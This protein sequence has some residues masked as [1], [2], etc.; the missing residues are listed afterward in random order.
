M[1]FFH[2][3]GVY[4]LVTRE[5]AVRSGKGKIIKGRWLDVNKG[6]SVNPDYRSRLVGKEFNTGVDSTLY[7]AAPGSTE[8][9][10]QH[11]GQ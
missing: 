10:D 11:S 2:K 9:A 8:A 1:E 7:A 4:E 3:T 5:E 6:D